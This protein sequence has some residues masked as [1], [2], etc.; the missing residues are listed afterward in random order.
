MKMT[1]FNILLSNGYILLLPILIWNGI[2]GSKLPPSFDSKSFNKNIP[3]FILI[4][5]NLSR[6][7][8]FLL[9]LLMR[10][11]LSETTGTKGLIVYAFGS[12][13][14]YISWLL[15]MCF[16]DSAWSKSVFGFIAPAYT[17]VIWLSGIA[18]MV[19]S[20]YFDLSYSTW[21]FLIP[22]MSFAFFHIAHAALVYRRTYL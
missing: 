18:L 3:L 12:M 8:I 7:I 22:A 6:S 20:Y 4:G 16:P 1:V 13:L 15:L 19:D 5:E 17:P 21:H 10:I 9:P 11:N 14:Y 2:F